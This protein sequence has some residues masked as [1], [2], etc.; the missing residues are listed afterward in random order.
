MAGTW[1]AVVKGFAGMRVRDGRVSFRPRLPEHWTGLTFHVYF[2]ENILS[3]DLQREQTIVTNVSGGMLTVS[4]ESQ[5]FQ[6]QPNAM[7]AVP[8]TKTL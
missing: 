2:R 5:T 4:I 8:F 6:L 1:L 7:H 3:V